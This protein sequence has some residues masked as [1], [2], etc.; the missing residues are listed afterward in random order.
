MVIGPGAGAR[1]LSKPATIMHHAAMHSAA[2]KNLC[3]NPIFFE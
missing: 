3:V 1:Y 2:I